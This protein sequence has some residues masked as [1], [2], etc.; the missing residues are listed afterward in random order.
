VG[1]GKKGFENRVVE[2]RVGGKYPPPYYYYYYYYYYIYICI[3]I[4]IYIYIYS[5]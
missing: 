5:I 3:Y 1:G 4:Y 2:T